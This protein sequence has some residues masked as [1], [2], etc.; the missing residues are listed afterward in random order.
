MGER[1]SCNVRITILFDFVSD[2]SIS[3]ITGGCDLFLRGHLAEI[4]DF[5]TI[6]YTFSPVEIMRGGGQNSMLILIVGEKN[7]GEQV[8]RNEHICD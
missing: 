4:I 8:D 5:V 6:S 3:C 2:R 1:V 7:S